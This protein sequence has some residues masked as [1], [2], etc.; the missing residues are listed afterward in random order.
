MSTVG[1]LGTGRMGAAMGQALVAAGH[2]LV[3]WNRTISTAHDLVDRIGA[4]R[5][6][7]VDRP[8]EVAAAATVCI[9]MLADGTA[10]DDVYGG[11]EGLI[12]GAAPGRVLCDC[13]TV[14]PSTL[15][16]HAAAAEAVGAGLLDTPVSG[17]TALAAGGK[18][19]IM[20]GGAHEHLEIARPVLDALATTVTHLGPLGSGAAMKLAVNTVI[21]GLNQS[22]AEALTLA[23]AA[24]IEPSLAYDVLTASAA[25]AP[26][27][28]YKR[29]AFLEPDATPVAFS[30]GLAHKDLL[31]I[32][33]LARSVGVRLPGAT[34]D[35]SVIEAAIASSGDSPDFSTVTTQLHR[36]AA[37][38]EG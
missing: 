27:V 32:E 8:R 36:P 17:S 1:L 21:F 16:G 19:T 24:G 11:P 38:Q 20:V 9:S 33:D 12:A 29:A 13:S 3:V 28:A 5:G 22:V 25:G 6:R 15:R 10:V 18:L 23:T 30:L 37:A 7:V 35:R 14:P 31:L 4:G 26:F 2:D 34:T